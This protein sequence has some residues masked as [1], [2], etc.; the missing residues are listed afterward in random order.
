MRR[1]L[2]LCFLRRCLCLQLGLLR[3]CR[4]GLF[5]PG[6]VPYRDALDEVA[7][8]VVRLPQLSQRLAARRL[9]YR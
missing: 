3:I 2:C 7:G 4:G 9:A 5:A 8:Q 1:G 6:V